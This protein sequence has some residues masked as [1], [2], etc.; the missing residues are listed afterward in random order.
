[1]AMLRGAQLSIRTGFITHDPVP[2][3]LVDA[4][5]ELQITR[6]SPRGGFQMKLR[7]AKGGP[8]VMAS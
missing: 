1:M 3:A 8:V 7:L 6:Q 5:T 2:Q 4:I